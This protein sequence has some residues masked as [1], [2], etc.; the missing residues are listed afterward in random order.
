MLRGGLC[1]NCRKKDQTRKGAAGAAEEEP[2]LL[3]RSES[4][5]ER[6]REREE[7]PLLLLRNA[8]AAGPL[9]AT[10]AIVYLSVRVRVRASVWSR[11]MCRLDELSW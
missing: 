11:T 1:L 7:E 2:L 5:R 9:Q 8:S 10:G 3:L 4:E 6:E